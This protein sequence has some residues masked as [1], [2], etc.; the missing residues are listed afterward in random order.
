MNIALA[1]IFSVLAV[2]F[3]RSLVGVILGGSFVGKVGAVDRSVTPVRFWTGIVFNFLA[4]ALFA[5]LSVS[6]LLAR[7]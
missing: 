7:A 6:F 4:V 2:L 3:M 1:V 5:I